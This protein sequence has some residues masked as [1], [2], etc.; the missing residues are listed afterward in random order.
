MVSSEGYSGPYR[1][2]VRVW[3]T[4]YNASHGAWSRDDPNYGR[5]ASGAM[6]DHGIC[7][8]DPSAI[9]LGTRF[10]VPGYGVCLAADTG[11]GIQG[12]KIDLGFPEAAGSN[13]WTTGFV[14]IYTLD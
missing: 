10:M 14:E 1:Q 2:K 6:L 13:P 8:V 3:A 12:W 11:G 9:P 4:W 5:T 7:A